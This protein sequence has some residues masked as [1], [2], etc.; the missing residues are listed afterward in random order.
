MNKADIIDIRDKIITTALPN[1]VFDGWGWP[2][3]V[4]AASE[5]GYD[6]TMARA[7]FP[8]KIVSALAH[9]SEMANQGMIDRLSAIN[10]QDLRVRDRIK[11]AVMARFEYL[12]V[13][14]E[15]VRESLGVLAWPTRKPK[16]AQMVWHTAD[17]IWGWA[18]DEAR[19]YNRYTKRGLLSA[20]LVATTL[21][22]LDDADEDMHT[23]RAFLDRRIDNVMFLGRTIGP[24]MQKFKMAG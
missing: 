13:H 15:A 22:W 3:V 12:Q 8:D 23:T 11:V 5:C 16:A 1:V 7:V 17:V 14:K 10:A 4:R 21:V 19:D 6:E 2:V 18:G 9:F 20:I 24:F